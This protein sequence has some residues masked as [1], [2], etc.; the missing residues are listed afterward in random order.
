MDKQKTKYGIIEIMPNG[1]IFGYV[2][3]YKMNEEAEVEIMDE[4]LDLGY[5]PVSNK[6][7]VSGGGLKY[8]EF[9]FLDEDGHEQEGEMPYVQHGILIMKTQLKVHVPTQD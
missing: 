6:Y 9:K 1:K 7:L 3:I 4:Y 2:N 5:I 8:I